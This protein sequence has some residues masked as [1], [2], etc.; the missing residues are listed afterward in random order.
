MIALDRDTHAR[1]TAAMQQVDDAPNALLHIEAKGLWSRGDVGRA[2]GIS[3]S[4]LR[5]IALGKRPSKSQLSA[6]KFAFL[7]RLMGLGKC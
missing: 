2:S 3:G 4:T 1:A 7:C 6:L 5:A